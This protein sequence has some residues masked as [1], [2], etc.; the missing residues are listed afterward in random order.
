[1]KVKTNLRA[2][3]M[4]SGLRSL[5]VGPIPVAYNLVLYSTRCVGV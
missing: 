4:A 5:L 3:R 1:M 2:G